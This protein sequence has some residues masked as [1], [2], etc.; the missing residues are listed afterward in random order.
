MSDGLHAPLDTGNVPL[1]LSGLGI[2]SRESARWHSTC[3]DGGWFSASELVV[4]HRSIRLRAAA[5]ALFVSNGGHYEGAI[6]R[7]L[8]RP[9][10]RWISTPTGGNRLQGEEPQLDRSIIPFA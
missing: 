6:D 9:V 5:L 4:A 2:K 10:L 8:S 3:L 1:R 7:G